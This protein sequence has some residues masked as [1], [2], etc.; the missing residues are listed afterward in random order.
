MQEEKKLTGLQ[1]F[2]KDKPTPEEIVIKYCESEKKENALAFIACLEENKTPLRFSRSSPNLFEAKYKSKNICNLTVAW[3]TG[4][5]KVRLQLTHVESYKEA[6][7]NEA[8]Q[9]IIWNS[10]AFCIYSERSPYFGMKKAPGCSPNKPCKGGKNK[11]VLGKEVKVC[12]TSVSFSNPDD[13]AIK[14]MKRLLELEK[15]A[16]Y[17]V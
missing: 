1:Q 8:L 3:Q 12:H 5:W 7:F 10:L 13:A 9:E 11:I 2:I 15:Q 6:I 16:R 14:I 17:N 4:D